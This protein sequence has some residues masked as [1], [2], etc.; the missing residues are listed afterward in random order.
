[1]EFCRAKAWHALPLH[2]GASHCG[3][4]AEMAQRS[5]PIVT[6]LPLAKRTTGRCWLSLQGQGAE[7]G[8]WAVTLG[9]MSRASQAGN[10]TPHAGLLA[11]SGTRGCGHGGMRAFCT[12]LEHP[13]CCMRA[14]ATASCRQAATQG[15]AQLE[16]AANKRPAGAAT[17]SPSP[18]SSLPELLHHPAGAVDQALSVADVADEHDLRTNLQG[19][20]GGQNWGKGY[21]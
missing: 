4:P 5:R 19:V 17:S 11:Q 2:T 3:A 7:A 20:A 15:R 6:T 12:S 13:S 21:N 18:S 10:S 14:H 8:S 1:M 16:P 9:Q